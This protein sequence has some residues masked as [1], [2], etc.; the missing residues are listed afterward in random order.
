[1]ILRGT[2]IHRGE[3][4]RC[5]LFSL[6]VLSCNIAELPISAVLANSGTSFRDPVVSHGRFKQ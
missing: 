1:M 6:S 5:G 3:H 2:E 4:G